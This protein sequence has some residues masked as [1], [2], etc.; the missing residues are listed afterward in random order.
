[1]K[2]TIIVILAV[3]ALILSSCGTAKKERITREAQYAAMYA[4][5][6]VTLLV[7]PPI[8]KTSFVD[9]KELLY[10]SISKPLAERGYYVISPFLAMEILKAESAYDSEMFID[11]PLDKFNSFFGADAVVFSEINTWTK[12]GMGIDTEIRYIIKMARTGEVVFDRSCDLY[13]DL[14]VDAGSNSLIGSLVSLTASA[15]NT[16][17]TNHIEAARMANSYI[18]RD[19][20]FG[21]YSPGYDEDRGFEAEEANIRAIVK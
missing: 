12:R 3:S 5:R 15:I 14:S 6:P 7:M 18:F 10:T 20:P 4:Y 2:K 17:V 11:A 16:A 8:N 13:L 19:M 9:A 21:K 1:M